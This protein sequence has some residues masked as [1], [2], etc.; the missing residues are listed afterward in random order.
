MAEQKVNKTIASMTKEEVRALMRTIGTP[1]MPFPMAFLKKGEKGVME[2]DVGVIESATNPLVIHSELSSERVR[3]LL[4]R[5]MPIP[6]MMLMLRDLMA[7]IQPES[8]NRIMTVF[9]DAAFGKSHLFK[10][11]GGMVHPQG[12]IAV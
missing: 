4:M 10:L 12:P 11:V 7:K 1:G 8:K 5:Q 6:G 2:Q 9:G 3:G